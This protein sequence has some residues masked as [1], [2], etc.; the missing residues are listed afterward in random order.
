MAELCNTE[1]AAGAYLSFSFV[2]KDTNEIIINGTSYPL[3]ISPTQVSLG[4]CFEASEVGEGRTLELIVD[5]SMRSISYESGGGYKLIPALRGMN[6]NV[7]TKV[8]G[9]VTDTAGVPI[10][11]AEVRAVYLYDTVSTLTTDAGKYQLLVLGGSVFTYTITAYAD[12]YTTADTIYTLP[13]ISSGDS[14]INYSFKLK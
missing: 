3:I 8:T 10:H 12:G 4:P 6:K 9:I 13:E 2:F 5:L 14:L 11:N 7:S 1:I